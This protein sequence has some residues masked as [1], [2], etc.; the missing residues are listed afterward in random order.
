MSKRLLHL[1]IIVFICHSIS[2]THVLCIVL[3]PSLYLFLGGGGKHRI[4]DIAK[5]PSVEASNED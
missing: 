4:K 5:Q 3:F 1:I 2:Y